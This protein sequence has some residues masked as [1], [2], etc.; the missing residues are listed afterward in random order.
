MG[1]CFKESR[2]LYAAGE[3]ARA[4]VL[5]NEGKRHKAAMEILHKEASAWIFRGMYG[6]WG[7]FMSEW[8]QFPVGR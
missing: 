7:F 8:S 3:R 4:K 1:R 2:Q 5:S 6:F